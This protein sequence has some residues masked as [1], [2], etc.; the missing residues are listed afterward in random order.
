MPEAA[1]EGGLVFDVLAFK[2]RGGWSLLSPALLECAGLGLVLSLLSWRWSGWCRLLAG[3]AFLVAMGIHLW[4][5]LAAGRACRLSVAEDQVTV[6]RRCKSRLELCDPPEGWSLPH[7]R[8]REVVL[9][10]REGRFAEVV[11]NAEDAARFARAVRI[12][13]ALGDVRFPIAKCAD[14]DERSGFS[15]MV[16]GVVA[17]ALG[18]TVWFAAA[19][20]PALLWGMVVLLGALSVGPIV[21]A[22]FPSSL[23]GVVLRHARLVIDAP[24]RSRH[25]DYREVES[26]ARHATRL[27]VALKDGTT[28]GLQTWSSRGLS[29]RLFAY[30][31]GPPFLASRAAAEEYAKLLHKELK[32]AVDRFRSDGLLPNGERAPVGR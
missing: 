32:G 5:R 17:C 1:S 24:G 10:T 12:D 29:A 27:D 13:P 20:G 3:V 25:V 30:W 14:W 21:Y 18:L 7:V 28:I 8:G 15:A 2:V 11:L 31:G 16:L 26:I 6:K 9:G 4:S 19:E 22:S 23:P